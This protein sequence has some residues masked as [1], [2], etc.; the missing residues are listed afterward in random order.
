VQ[1]VNQVLKQY[2]Q[3]RKMFKSVTSSSFMAKR[4]MNM[5]MPGQQQ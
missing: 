4:L 2:L 1:E 3:M 5:R